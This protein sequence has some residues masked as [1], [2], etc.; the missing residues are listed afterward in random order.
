MHCKTDSG[1]HADNS[2]LDNATIILFRVMHQW[3][4]LSK[5]DTPHHVL[6]YALCK[7]KDS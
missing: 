6:I 3:G 7:V 2:L 1:T 5:R 4:A